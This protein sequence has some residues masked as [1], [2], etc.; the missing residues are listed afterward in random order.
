MKRALDFIRGA[1]FVAIIGR[2]LTGRTFIVEIEPTTE[3]A[4]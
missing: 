1:R 2:H 3:A 4:E